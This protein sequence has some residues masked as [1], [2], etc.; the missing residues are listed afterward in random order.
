VQILVGC[1]PIPRFPVERFISD[2]RIPQYEG[3]NKSR[4][5]CTLQVDLNSHEPTLAEIFLAFYGK[6]GNDGR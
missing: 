5:K 3:T 6:G 4:R 2:A 1:G